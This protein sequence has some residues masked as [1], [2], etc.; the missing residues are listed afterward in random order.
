MIT[1]TSFYPFRNL[2]RITQ[3][4]YEDKALVRMRSLTLEREFEF[5]YAEVNEISYVNQ[6]NGSQT[7]FGFEALAFIGII[8]IVCSKIIYARPWLILL[9]Q[10]SYVLAVI[11][12]LTG[13]IKNRY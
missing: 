12:F 10:S 1:I 9:T 7:M 2:L 13:F 5:S 4:F 8:L 6:A 3:E 11:I